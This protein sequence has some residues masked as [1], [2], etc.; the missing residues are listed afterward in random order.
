[1][2]N[3]SSQWGQQQLQVDP[4]CWNQI[5]S[6]GTDPQGIVLPSPSQLA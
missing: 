6:F 5:P 4:F 1:M 2:V 3:T